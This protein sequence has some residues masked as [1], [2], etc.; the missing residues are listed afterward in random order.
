[1]FLSAPQLPPGLSQEETCQKVPVPEEEEAAGHAGHAPAAQE[2]QPGDRGDVQGAPPIH[3]P[4]EPPAGPVSA[5][6]GEDD[7]PP[8]EN[9]TAPQL[10]VSGVESERGKRSRETVKRGKNK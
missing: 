1:M 7:E 10:N 5:A 6:A 2:V 3:A 4:T 9:D 8:G